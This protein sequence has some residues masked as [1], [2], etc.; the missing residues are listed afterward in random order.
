VSAKDTLSSSSP[1]LSAAGDGDWR[2]HSST[3]G[4]GLACHLSLSVLS[5]ALQHL[6]FSVRLTIVRKPTSRIKFHNYGAGFHGW[7]TSL[8]LIAGSREVIVVESLS[9]TEI[10][11]ELA[12][13][14]L[15]LTAALSNDAKFET[16]SLATN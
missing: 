14:S 1:F 10:D 6:I 2:S 15:T 12:C 5:S 4:C 3:E 11:A 7:P 9:R 8:H 16:V 13:D